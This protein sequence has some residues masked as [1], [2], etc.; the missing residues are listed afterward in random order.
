MELKMDDYFL[1]S[2]DTNQGPVFFRQSPF[3]PIQRFQA[4]SIEKNIPITELIS[5][6][7][8]PNGWYR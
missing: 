1:M 7:Y 4:E 5:Q 8:M 2:I 3:S 6:D